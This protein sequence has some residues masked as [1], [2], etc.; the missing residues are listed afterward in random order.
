MKR[1]ELIR[2]IKE[3][4]P[5]CVKTKFGGETMYLNLDTRDLLLVLEM[6]PSL[7]NFKA[8]VIGERTGED[9]PGFI[10]WLD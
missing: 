5:V 8:H 10:V 1:T 7:D 6:N 2:R 3:E 4:S 9:K